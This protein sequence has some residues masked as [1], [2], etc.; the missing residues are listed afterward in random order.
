MTVAAAGEYHERHP[1]GLRRL[2]EA[3]RHEE[4]ERDSHCSAETFDPAARASV[5]RFVT[6]N[7]V[8]NKQ[9]GVIAGMERVIDLIEHLKFVADEN[10]TC[11]GN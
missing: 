1:K 3:N 8:S 2:H 9:G 7:D 10:T 11:Y 5:G 6:Q 4:D